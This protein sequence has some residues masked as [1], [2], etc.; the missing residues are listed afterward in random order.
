M[1]QYQ[2]H[3]QQ[4]EQQIKKIRQQLTYAVNTNENKY[5]DMTLCRMQKEIHKQKQILNQIYRL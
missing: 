2:M 3:L 4:L 1:Q 5:L